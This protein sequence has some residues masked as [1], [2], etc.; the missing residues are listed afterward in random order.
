MIAPLGRFSFRGALWYQGE[1][2]VGSPY[3]DL[4]A[5]LFA[6]W[7]SQF[8]QDML[9]GVVQ[10]A[11]YGKRVAQPAESATARLREDQRLAVLNDP[12]AV[13]VTAVDAGEPDDIHPANKK[14]I[15]ER[16]ARAVGVRL[17]GQLGSAAGP[18]IR[19][20][21]ADGKRIVLGFD[22]VEGGLLAYG[23]SRPIGFETCGPSGCQWADAQIEGSEVMLPDGPGVRTVRYCWADAP[24]CTLYES[25]SGL[26]AFPFEQQVQR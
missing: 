4:L 1:S 14:L 2:N 26:P 13:L 10:L 6:D 16:L 21:R 25:K 20:A 18:M 22:G 8:G 24:T 7:R 5:R 15:G 17:Y 3:R 12:N 23:A 9:F 19:S 11:N